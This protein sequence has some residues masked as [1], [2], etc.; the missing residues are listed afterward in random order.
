MSIAGVGLPSG[1]SYF[2]PITPVFLSVGLPIEATAILF[3]VDAIPDMIETA[4]NVTAD[5]ATTAALSGM[6]PLDSRQATLP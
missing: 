3:A 6:T 2:G 5:L 1:A 4:T